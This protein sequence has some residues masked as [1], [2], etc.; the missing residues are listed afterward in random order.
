MIVLLIVI[1]LVYSAELT[2][3]VDSQENQ[4]QKSSLAQEV[5]A[6]LVELKQEDISPRLIEDSKDKPLKTEVTYQQEPNKQEPNK[7]TALETQEKAVDESGTL[8]S[9]KNAF[10][11][12][13]ATEVQQIKIV[14][15]VQQT[16]EL[17]TLN[18]LSFSLYFD[19]YYSH[20]FN[21]R[22]FR[23]LEYQRNNPVSEPTTSVPGSTTPGA[24]NNLHYYNWYANQIILNLAELSLKY[25]KKNV[26]LLIDLDFGPFADISMQ[27]PVL[28]AS[29]GPLNGVVDEVHKHI[30]QA[31]LSYTPEFLPGLLLEVGKLP[32]HISAEYMKAKDNW[33]YTRSI[34]FSFGGPFWHTGLH[35]AYSIIPDR[36]I[37]NVYIYQGWNSFYKKNSNFVYG[38]QLKWVL[39]DAFNVVYNYIGGPEQL[40]NTKNIRQL[41]ELV[42]SLNVSPSVSIMADYVNGNEQGALDSGSKMA[43]WE[44]VSIAAKWDIS[45]SHSFRPRLEVY[46]DNNGYTLGGSRQAIR[47]YT[48]THAM[49]VTNGLELRLESRFDYSTNKDRFIKGN[50]DASSMQR[51]LTLGVLCIL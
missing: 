31:I 3:P 29:G 42:L 22:S 36:L 14:E 47:T 2:P 25:Q 24:Q 13:P 39:S 20:N 26:T 16:P 15:V 32:N 45:Q 23:A 50:G 38:T 19:A 7:S 33:N 41:N 40:V 12:V 18:G 46:Y 10:A 30:G 9:S 43:S 35:G 8:Q 5:K 34:A 17:A 51:T 27:T 44:G 37:S 6:K 48:L 1:G 28:T 49:K 11:T 4:L 21:I